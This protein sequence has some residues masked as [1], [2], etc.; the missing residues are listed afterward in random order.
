MTLAAA[1]H[2]VMA[3]TKFNSYAPSP[4]T[5]KQDSNE[6]SLVQMAGFIGLQTAHVLSKYIDTVRWNNAF[7]QCQSARLSIGLV[8]S[9][10]LRNALNSVQRTAEMNG[11]KLSIPVHEY[12][13]HY[14]KLPLTDCVLGIQTTKKTVLMLRVL[15]PVMKR[16]T[17]YTRF[18]LTKIPY[19]V[20]EGEEKKICEIDSFDPKD[21]FLVEE[22]LGIPGGKPVVTMAPECFES[23]LCHISEQPRSLVVDPCLK[24]LMNGSV[25]HIRDYC[26]FECYPIE[27]EEL[28]LPIIIKVAN[29]QYS[30]TGSHKTIP[31][32][33]Y[34][35]DHLQRVLDPNKTNGVMQVI[36]P[37]NCEIRFKAEVYR[38]SRPCE[39][40]FEY[41]YLSSVPF[42]VDFTGSHPTPEAIADKID[43]LDST[44]NPESKT[45]KEQE[46]VDTADQTIPASYILPPEGSG[47]FEAS[48][49]IPAVPPASLLTGGSHPP[50]PSHTGQLVIIWLL[51]ILLLL[52][53]GLLIY[54]AYVNR[55]I[56][57][58][59]I[60]A[61]LTR[62]GIGGTT[63]PRSRLEED[64]PSYPGTITSVHHTNGVQSPNV[65]QENNRNSAASLQSDN[66]MWPASLNR[67]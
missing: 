56:D 49:G 28:L 51:L 35:D 14:Y 58:G 22:T 27:N 13:P 8:N 37:C 6:A 65:V 30:I 20:T 42:K 15:I 52:S 7:T 41:H 18:R 47:V 62:W 21:D 50:P 53:N 66:T 43:S 25:D 54:V 1:H 40:P 12:L 38:S 2:V 39:Q 9:F 17:K 31:I 16:D 11:Y 36:L 57:L 24:G 44:S 34:C 46:N 5:I 33:V 3:S 55:L 64:P 4:A 45:E 48:S 59:G 67:L 32:N 19:L 29:N 63:P 60:R 10:W 23:E 61:T 26:S